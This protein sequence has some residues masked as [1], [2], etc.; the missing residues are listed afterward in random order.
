MNVEDIT[1]VM[2]VA[3]AA[4]KKFEEAGNCEIASDLTLAAEAFA[5][6]VCFALPETEETEID[7]L[8]GAT[9]KAVAAAIDAM[10]PSNEDGEEEKEEEEGEE[11]E[12]DVGDNEGAQGGVSAGAG[13][14]NENTGGDGVEGEEEAVPSKTR[15]GK[16]YFDSDMR[17]EGEDRPAPGA[18]MFLYLIGKCVQCVFLLYLARITHFKCSQY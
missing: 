6:A 18:M 12:E 15:C 7:E 14:G 16:V 5:V 1:D 17:N 3:I 2:A 10:N 13:G 4:A 8:I 11:E 9:E